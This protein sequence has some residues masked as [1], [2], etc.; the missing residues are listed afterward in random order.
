[1]LASRVYQYQ[2]R[3]TIVL[4]AEWDIEEMLTAVQAEKTK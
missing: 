3:N 2:A 4:S 1:M